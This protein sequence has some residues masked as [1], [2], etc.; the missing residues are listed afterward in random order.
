MAVVGSMLL[1]SIHHQRGVAKYIARFEVIQN[2]HSKRMQTTRK[3]RNK[4]REMK[5]DRGPVSFLF[6]YQRGM[7]HTYTPTIYTSSCPILFLALDA[8]GSSYVVQNFI[9]NPCAWI[10]SRLHIFHAQS[11]RRPRTRCRYITRRGP[12]SFVKEKPA[13]VASKRWTVAA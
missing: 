2:F 4:L 8:P 7:P 10:P 1:Y 3:D 6:P 5:K 13:E 12:S 9:Q 11:P